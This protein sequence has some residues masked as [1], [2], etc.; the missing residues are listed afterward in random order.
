MMCIVI[1]KVFLFYCTV[2]RIHW[3]DIMLE[4]SFGTWAAY[5][6]SKFANIL[7]TREL[8]KR[9]PQDVTTY[10]LH[11]GAVKT[12]IGNNFKAHYGTPAKIL[13]FML[14]PIFFF[15]FKSAKQG[16]QTTI[17][18]CVDEQLGSSSGKFYADCQEKQLLAHALNDDEALRLWEMS[19]ELVK[20][21]R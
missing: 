14:Q 12:D 9:L 15:V 4:K 20:N 2:G 11:P 19:D 5:A 21:F 6:Q 1:G 13:E 3:D 8:A 16:A 17:F 18:C 10:A 7:F